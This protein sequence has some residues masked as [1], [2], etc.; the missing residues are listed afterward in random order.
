MA[1]PTGGQIGWV[2]LELPH[3][4]TGLVSQ[5]ELELPHG[6]TG[7]ISWAELQVGDV[8]TA[9]Q[10]TQGWVETPNVAAAGLVSQAWVDTPNVATGG[11]IGQSF[12]TVPFIPTAGQV[13]WTE[14]EL[15]RAATAGR[16]GR[17]D[18]ELP[19]PSQ[20]A[21]LG[22]AVLRVPKPYANSFTLFNGTVDI[23]RTANLS[24]IQAAGQITQVEMTAAGV[25]YTEPDDIVITAVHSDDTG[26]PDDAVLSANVGAMTTKTGTY[27]TT[28]GFLSADKFLQDEFYY[29]DH[30]YVIRVAE[31][32][33]RWQL[34][35]KKI[36]HPA[37]FHLI[38]E[39]VLVTTPSAFVLTAEDAIVIES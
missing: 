39:F 25:Y 18:F 8:A 20:A 1:D 15:R 19:R 36:L 34:I 17:V 21:V 11:Q 10:V 22:Y 30:T 33:D 23:Y 32:F 6:H 12:F 24:A 37:G 28:K 13:G 27:R 5:A 26:D 16:I 29:N 2:E 9:G 31:S 4:H 38:G 3:G 35:Y 7:D 14:F